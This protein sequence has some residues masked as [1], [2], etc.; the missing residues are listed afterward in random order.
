MTN[1]QYFYVT[2]GRATPTTPPD[3]I[4]RTDLAGPQYNAE[5]LD[6][7]GRW[8]ASEFLMRYHWRGTTEDDH[9][10]ISEERAIEIIGKWVRARRLSRWPDEPAPLEGWS[11]HQSRWTLKNFG[12][13]VHRKLHRQKGDG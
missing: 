4:G 7:E 9:V 12:H 1:W 13:Q 11:P 2:D 6:R 10:K 5:M 3:G 8:R